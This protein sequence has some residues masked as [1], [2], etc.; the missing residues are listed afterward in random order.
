MED[1]VTERSKRPAVIGQADLSAATGGFARIAYGG[2][3]ADTLYGL[4]GSD[5]LAGGGAGDRIHADNGDDRAYGGD[6]ADTIFGGAGN[7]QLLGGA[8]NDSVVGGHGKDVLA[9][10]AGDD[11]LLGGAGADTLQGGGGNDAYV[12]SPGD[13]NDQIDG[14][15]GDG[16]LQLLNTGLTAHEFY[17]ALSV[18]GRHTE[19]LS[20]RFSEDGRKV[21]V[22]GLTGEVTINGETISFQG[23]T[24]IELVE[25]QTCE[26]LGSAAS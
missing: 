9:G 19:N 3:K 11:T 23:L 4:G 2:D 18:W 16:T 5:L 14:A 10:D 1:Q 12:W 21:D 8:D 20:E 7:D 25:V 15:S 13:A 17:F 22:G 24:T 26:A 6:G